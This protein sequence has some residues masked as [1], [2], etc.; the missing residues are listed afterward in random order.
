[1]ANVLPS[2]TSP[3]DELTDDKVAPMERSASIYTTFNLRLYDFVV[4]VISNALAWRCSTRSVLLPF[5]GKHT[6]ESSAHLEVGSGTGYY[7]AMAASSGALSKTR[8]MTLCDLNPDTLAY[9]NRRIAGVG[10]RGSIET[11]E[12]NIFQPL[13]Q[14][15]CGKYDSIA[16]YYLLQCLP[17]S[18]PKKAIGVFAN[19]APALA[20]NGVL[21]GAIVL[22]EGVAHNWFGLQLMSLYNKSVFLGT[23]GIRRR[24]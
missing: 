9:S 14:D 11:I 17:G 20:P 22:G 12:H 2:L 8:L 1:M 21:Y 4:L 19:V 6:K 16:L 24:G 13:A 3:N 5:Y 10:Y 18:F 15:M 7:P 23:L